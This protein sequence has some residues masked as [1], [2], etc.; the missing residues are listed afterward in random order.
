MKIQCT[1]MYN[2]I[3]CTNKLTLH[4]WRNEAKEAFR[5]SSW[6]YTWNVVKQRRWISEKS[7]SENAIIW[8]L[9]PMII[10]NRKPLKPLI[11]SWSLTSELNLTLFL[12]V[13]ALAQLQQC[14]AVSRKASEKIFQFY[15]DSVRRRYSK[16]HEWDACDAFV[17]FF[18]HCM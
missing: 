16:M 17:F 13:F 1:I 3:L 11:L 15:R 10:P 7:L 2:S 8:N 12:P 6:F 9:L 14:I 5:S 18:T 4:L